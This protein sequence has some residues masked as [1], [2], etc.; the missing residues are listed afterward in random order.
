MPKGLVVTALSNQIEYVTHNGK[1]LI[2]GKRENVTDDAINA[3]FEH[4]MREYQ[5]RISKGE[6]RDSFGYYFKGFGTIKYF[7]EDHVEEEN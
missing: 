2:T 5:T 4:M 3:V 1:G 7:P 6:E